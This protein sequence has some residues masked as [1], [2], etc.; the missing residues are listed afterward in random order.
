MPEERT[1]YCGQ[2]GTA[3]A[4]PVQEDPK[5]IPAWV[6]WVNSTVGPAEIPKQNGT[7]I[8]VGTL[9]RSKSCA[10]VPS[11]GFGV[12]TNPSTMKVTFNPPFAQAATF[13]LGSR[14]GSVS[15]EVKTENHNQSHG[16][17]VAGAGIEVTM[18][19][20]VKGV[21]GTS[22]TIVVQ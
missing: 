17:I 19:C 4:V 18:N 7:S 2:T 8:F 1:E 16:N 13:P 5:P 9:Q 22:K 11:I 21:P 15:W 3:E 10:G 12:S 14:L 6:A 20:E